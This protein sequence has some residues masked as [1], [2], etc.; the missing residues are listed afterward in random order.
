LRQPSRPPR[1]EKNGD[2]VRTIDLNGL[3]AVTLVSGSV[4]DTVDS[5]VP[6][7]GQPKKAQFIAESGLFL[8]GDQFVAVLRHGSGF[9]VENPHK[10]KAI[11]IFPPEGPKEGVEIKPGGHQELPGQ[12]VVVQFNGRSYRFRSETPQ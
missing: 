2:G 5:F 4:V 9:R 11:K 7:K 1:F 12:Q 3:D 8:G 6:V 10:K